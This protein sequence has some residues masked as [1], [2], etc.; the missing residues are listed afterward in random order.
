MPQSGAWKKCALWGRAGCT[1]CPQRRQT[2]SGLRSLEAASPYRG[3]AK[4]APDAM[5]EARRGQREDAGGG[6]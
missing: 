2:G 6:A 5:G 4:A 1:T 3:R